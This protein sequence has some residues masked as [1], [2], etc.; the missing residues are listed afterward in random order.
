MPELGRLH[1]AHDPDNLLLDEFTL[2]ALAERGFT[3]LAFEDEVDFR[4]EYETRFRGRWDDGLPTETP[5]VLMHYA[6]EE[7]D[8]LPWNLTQAAVIHR[9]S[10]L[11]YSRTWN[12]R[13][14]QHAR[15]DLEPTAR[16]ISGTRPRRAWRQRNG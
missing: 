15:R 6:G 7:L 4:L 9:L 2:S 1:L 5:A 3:V 8:D 12:C 16:P 11:E 14:A 10:L 13:G